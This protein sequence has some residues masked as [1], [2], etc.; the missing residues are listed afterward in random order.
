VAARLLARDRDVDALRDSLNAELLAMM[1]KDAAAVSA[2][3]DLV[4]MVQSV[5][6]VGDHAKSIAEYVVNVVEG[7][8]VRHGAL[9]PAR[10]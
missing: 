5:E 8:D 7:V 9:D 4:F 1:A 10:N 6:R 3:M 2:A